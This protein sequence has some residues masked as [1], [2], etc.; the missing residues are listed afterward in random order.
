MVI[1]LIVIYVLIRQIKFCGPKKIGGTN[2]PYLKRALGVFGISVVLGLTWVFGAFIVS[3]GSD[4]F[5]Y[6][7]VI[8][9]TFQGFLFFV[10]IVIVGSEGRAFWRNLLF[11]KSSVRWFGWR[12][13]ATKTSSLPRQVPMSPMTSKIDMLN[14]IEKKKDYEASKENMTFVN[15]DSVG[16]ENELFEMSSVNPNQ[17]NGSETSNEESEVDQSDP[18]SNDHHSL[19]DVVIPIMVAPQSNDNH[20]LKDVAIPIGSTY[21]L[22]VGWS[23]PDLTKQ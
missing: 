6:L 3:E 18:N 1:F 9:N 10:F 21:N 12:S 8:F 13:E 14:S 17:Q 5:R 19:Q 22:T 16:F 7:F 2:P 15:T 20:S 23:Q 11:P 4:V